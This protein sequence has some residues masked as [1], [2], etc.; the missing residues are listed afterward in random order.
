MKTTLKILTLIAL[1]A[2][3]LSLAGP[4]TWRTLFG[5]K[6]LVVYGFGAAMALW[7]GGRRIGTLD[8]ISLRPIFVVLGVIL[9]AAAFLIMFETRDTVRSL[10]EIHGSA[11]SIQPER[12]A[13]TPPFGVGRIV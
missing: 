3:Y 9:M 5:Q 11:P 7:F 13:S 10:Q 1:L 8:P 2:F 6:L 12:R 4:P